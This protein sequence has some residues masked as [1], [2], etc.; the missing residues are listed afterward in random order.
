MRT[1]LLILVEPIPNEFMPSWYEQPNSCKKTA[2]IPA[3]HPPNFVYAPH[4]Y[5]L[6][7][8]FFKAYQGM[9]VN[10]Q[11]LSR[12]MLLP[13]ALYFGAAGLAKKYVN[14]LTT[15]ICIKFR[16]SCAKARRL[17]GVSPC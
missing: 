14:P 10:V 6:N 2:A 5:D 1:D 17:W 13:F 11:G 9:S 16:G 8:L 3:P 12:G 7:V 4:F 15:A